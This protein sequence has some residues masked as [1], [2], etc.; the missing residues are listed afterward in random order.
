M[1]DTPKCLEFCKPARPAGSVAAV[2]LPLLLT[3]HASGGIETT[4]DSENTDRAAA[5]RLALATFP[6]GTARR[7][8][9]IAAGKE[10]RGPSAGPAR[11]APA[12]GPKPQSSATP[13]LESRLMPLIAAHKGKVAVAVL[14]L[15]TGESFRYHASEVMPTASLI[16]FPVMIEA[17]RQAAAKQVDLDATLTLKKS[18]KVPGSGVLTYHFSDGATFKLRDAVRLMIAFSDNTATNL[19]LDAIG[20]GATAATMEMLGY[21]NT[22][23]HAKVFRRDTSVFPERSKQFGLGSTTPDEMIK[24]CAAVYRKQ[25][26]SPAACEEMLGHLRAC[27]DKDKFPR[28]LPP[29]TKVAFKTGSLDETRTAAGIIECPGG[30]VAVCVMSCQNQD[31]RWVPDNAGNRLCAEIARAVYDHFDRSAA[32]DAKAKKTAENRP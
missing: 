15:D 7:V 14:H 3:I 19:V 10:D 29:Q 23:I 8:V 2:A 17:Y 28:F 13:T 20:I 1:V 32:A 11:P 5:V 30:P 4:I 31:K 9:V 27:E 21:P 16:K 25:L 24:L 22:K 6:E 26:V 18:D 12:E